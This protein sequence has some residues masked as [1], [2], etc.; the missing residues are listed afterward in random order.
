MDDEELKALMLSM[1]LSLDGFVGSGNKEAQE[2]FYKVLGDQYL[3][4]K[5]SEG[6]FDFGKVAPKFPA[7]PGLQGIGASAVAPMGSYF[8]QVNMLS[9]Q[10]QAAVNSVMREAIFGKL[11]QAPAK[12]LLQ[13]VIA[14]Y[15]TRAITVAAVSVSVTVAKELLLPPLVDHI[16]TTLDRRAVDKAL[17][18]TF[19]SKDPEELAMRMNRLANGNTKE[20]AQLSYRD[21]IRRNRH[22]KGWVRETNP[23]ACTLCVWWARD[24]RVW[25]KDH[26]MPTHPGCGCRPKPVVDKSTRVS[27]EAIAR[28]DRDRK[29]MKQVRETGR[30][31]Q[32]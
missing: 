30:V 32:L 7:I 1:G 4:G 14:K 26:Y 15:A 31:Y 23:G 21:G 2:W 24:N 5:P 6:I 13:M 10:A 22:V 28:S 3:I 25:P 17:T 19:G 20:Y 16:T 11:P 18:T 12:A 29:I 9:A 27:E 8:A